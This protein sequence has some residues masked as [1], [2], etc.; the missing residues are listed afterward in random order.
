MPPWFMAT[1]SSEGDGVIYAVAMHETEEAISHYKMAIKLSPDFA[2]AYYNL[3]IVLFNAKMTEEAIDRFK[4]AI[5]I[6]P[7]FALAHNNLGNALF[8]KG[9]IKEAI[10]HYRETLRL[11]PGL[12]STQKNLEIALRRSE[13]L[14]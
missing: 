14:E 2:E 3:G 10:S 1:M 7:D 5:R 6:Q 11:K 13:K 4:E 12:V 8:Q 9:A